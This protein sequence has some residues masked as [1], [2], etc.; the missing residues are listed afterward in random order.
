[1]G[2]QGMQVGGGKGSDLMAVEGGGEFPSSWEV[3]WAS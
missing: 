3:V 1:M 2:G